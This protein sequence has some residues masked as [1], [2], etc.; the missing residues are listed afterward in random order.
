MKHMNKIQEFHMM[1]ERESRKR[2]SAAELD[3][4]KEKENEVR[5]HI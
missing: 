1:V 2:Y 4:S 3:F 5:D